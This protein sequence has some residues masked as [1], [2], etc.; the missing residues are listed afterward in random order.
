[1]TVADQL[2]PRLSR[3]AITAAITV[4]PALRICKRC[5]AIGRVS[6]QGVIHV[7]EAP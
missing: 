5:N 2:G 7:V 1:L 6:S 4:T 3:D